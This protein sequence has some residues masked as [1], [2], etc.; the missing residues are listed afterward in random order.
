MGGWAHA[1]TLDSSFGNYLLPFSLSRVLF[2]LFPFPSRYPIEGVLSYGGYVTGHSISLRRIVLHRASDSFACVPVLTLSV[3]AESPAAKLAL[4]GTVPL[5]GLDKLSRARSYDPHCLPRARDPFLHFPFL[6]SFAILYSYRVFYSPLR[7]TLKP[8]PLPTSSVEIL[9]VSQA[10]PQLHL[11]TELSQG[12][13][14]FRS[15]SGADQG[16]QTTLNGCCHSSGF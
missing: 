3:Q 1:H 6:S 13:M 11:T 8:L 12:I 4:R 14:G 7:Y 15:R 9:S 5:E 16:P 10:F 2:F